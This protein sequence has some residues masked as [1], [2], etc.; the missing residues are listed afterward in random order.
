MLGIILKQLNL[1]QLETVLEVKQEILRT[2]Y[3]V[4]DVNKTSNWYNRS[5]K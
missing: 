5:D 3:T 1:K 2:Q 4:N